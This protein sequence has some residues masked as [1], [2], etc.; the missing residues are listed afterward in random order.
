MDLQWLALLAGI[1]LLFFLTARLT[2]A[3]GKAEHIPAP[4][5]ADIGDGTVARFVP[6]LAGLLVLLVI[7][8]VRDLDA[9]NIQVTGTPLQDLAVQ[10]PQSTWQVDGH[11]PS[12]RTLV[13]PYDGNMEVVLMT[14]DDARGRVDESSLAPDDT[15]QWR[16]AATG[17]RRECRQ[18]ECFRFVHKT[19]R[20]KGSNDARHALY[21]YHVGGLF[22]ESQLTY[23]LANAWARV[24]GAVAHNGLIG[25]RL[26]GDLPD[27]PLLAETLAQVRTNLDK[28][29][30]SDVPQKRPGAGQDGQHRNP[31]KTQ[32]L[33]LK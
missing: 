32:A 3:D 16:H 29:V 22:T 19:W 15:G 27:Q 33:A 30:L 8:P 25:F 20:R 24:T 13:I 26:R 6:A 4:Q 10:Y 1:G 17:H 7:V 23:R 28:P 9:R 14:G 18:Q 12:H 11:T 21:L 31:G 5:P 2:P